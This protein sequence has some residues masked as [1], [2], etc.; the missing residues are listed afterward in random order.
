[1]ETLYDTVEKEDMSIAVAPIH[2]E[3]LQKYREK[4]PVIHNGI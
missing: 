4:V 1:M 3:F 2:S